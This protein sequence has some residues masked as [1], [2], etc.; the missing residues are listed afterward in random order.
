MA[1]C[2]VEVYRRP[3]GVYD[4]VSIETNMPAG[5]SIDDFKLKRAVCELRYD[6]SYLIYDRT[7][8][9]FHELKAVVP[10]LDVTIAQP[11]NSTAVSENGVFALETGQCRVTA[12]NPASNLEEFASICKMYFDTVSRLLEVRVFLRIGLRSIFRCDFKEFDKAREM[13]AS[14]KL[15]NLEEGPRFGVDLPASEVSF[16][17]QN[18][19]IGTNFRLVAENATIDILLPP[20]IDDRRSVHKKVVGLAL[21]VDTY[22][23]LPVE[24]SQWDPTVWIPQSI[25]RARK[26]ADKIVSRF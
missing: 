16:R 23:V 25:R 7:G 15:L 18:D 5:F 9:V 12:D 4:C 24:R 22:T 10:D 13:L 6:K 1:K 21:D 3:L 19:E 14:L 26:E 20:E 2:V 11:S 8:Q 17:W